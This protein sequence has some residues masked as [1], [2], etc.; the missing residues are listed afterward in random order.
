MSKN[1][2]Y[3][4]LHRKFTENFLY[5]SEPFT[6]SQAWID[7][8][9]LANHKE[10]TMIVRGNAVKVP[11]GSIGLSQ[12]SLGQRWLWS[13]DKVKRFIS[14]LKSAHMIA[15]SKNG[16]KDLYSIVNYEQY[17]QHRPSNKSTNGNASN[18]SAYQ[19]KEGLNNDKRKGHA[20]ALPGAPPLRKIAP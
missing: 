5:F 18:I 3:I 20:P 15:Q 12:K 16:V 9:L 7:L 2:G 4:L 19:N 13:R 17:Q 10:N 1:S 11:R 8:L 6:R 14:L